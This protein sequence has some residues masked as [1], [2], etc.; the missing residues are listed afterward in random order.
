[1]SNPVEY[2][3]ARIS[4]VGI[5]TRGT[6]IGEGVVTEPIALTLDTGC[7]TIVLGGTAG[8][9]SDLIHR[10]ARAIGRP[11]ATIP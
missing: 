3:Q 5:A 8:D 10:M 9:L 7:A 4:R 6:Q 1:M 2:A 11:V